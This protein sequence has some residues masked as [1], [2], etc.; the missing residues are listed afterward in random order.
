[1]INLNGEF[2]TDATVLSATNRSFQYA[3]GV[4]ETLKICDGKILFFEDHYFRLMSAMRILRMEIPMNFTM[5]FLED[6]IL[7]L[8]H[9]LNIEDSARA[10]ITVFRTGNGFYLP[11]EN[12]VGFIITAQSLAGKP[13]VI[14][15]SRYEVDLYKD[16]YV[17]A[18]LLS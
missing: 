7:L 6:Q 15:E 18:Q 11:V 9:K 14:N 3:D 16:F 17:P 8:S 2:S 4:F 5:E 13:Y 12:G 1:M 10:R